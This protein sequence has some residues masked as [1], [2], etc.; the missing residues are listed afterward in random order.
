MVKDKGRSKD[1]VSFKDGFPSSFSTYLAVSGYGFIIISRFI[2]R[3]H[4][5]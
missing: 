5:L 4:P 2:Q 1:T 3:F